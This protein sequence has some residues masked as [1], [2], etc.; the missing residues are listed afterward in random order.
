MFLDIQRRASVVEED[1]TY[2]Q[3]FLSKF[4]QEKFDYMFDTFFDSA[5][6]DGRIQKADIEAFLE[7]IRIYCNYAKSD[8]RYV[9][10]ND[11]MYAFYE[12]L[13][14]QVKAEKAKSAQSRGFDNWDEAIK[15]H[16]VDVDNISRNQWLNMWGKL[17]RKASGI[18]G[19]PNWVQ[20]L[21]SIFFTTID[22]DGKSAFSRVALK[23]ENRQN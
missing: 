23:C 5:N 4:Q 21:A 15:P 12:C 7:K 19:F 9:K 22:R 18:S 1:P 20:L 2:G 14:D 3:R 8:P 17:C 10:M 13:M 16:S 11:V 6:K